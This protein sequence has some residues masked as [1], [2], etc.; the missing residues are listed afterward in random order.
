MTVLDGNLV[1]PPI[2]DTW[3]ENPVFFLTKKNPMAAEN[4]DGLMVPW[5]SP[6]AM[7]S[8]MLFF[9]PSERE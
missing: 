2:V 1:E 4:E 5:Q 9:S 6:S 8:S 3:P 7:Y